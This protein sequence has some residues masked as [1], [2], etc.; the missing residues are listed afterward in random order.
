MALTDLQFAVLSGLAPGRQH[1]YALLKE[2]QA[3]LSRPVAVATGYACFEVMVARGWIVA[4]GEEV[5]H[6]RTRR[7]YAISP[8]GREVLAKRA[9]E[10]AKQARLAQDR[11]FGATGKTATA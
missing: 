2:A 5:V 8:A 10:L 3:Q 7:Y 4:D 6:G 9:S 11:L 1:G